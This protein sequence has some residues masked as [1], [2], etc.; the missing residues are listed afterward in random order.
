M[1]PGDALDALD[2][3]PQG[4][5]LVAI[6][7]LDPHVL[8]ARARPGL[9]GLLADIAGPPPADAGPSPAGMGERGPGDALLD[10]I[11]RVLG[12][13][14]AALD[15]DTPLPDLG[16][17]SM[18]AI[19]ARNALASGFGLDVP[20]RDLLLGRTLAE[21]ADLVAQAGPVPPAAPPPADAPPAEETVWEEG[22]L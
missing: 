18:M 19:Q 22:F 4:E 20:L 10:E 17:D 5:A 6:G 15:L 13:E 14:R 12:F 3:V 16:F 11:A 2:A 7:A 8:Q 21:L 9:A 1:P